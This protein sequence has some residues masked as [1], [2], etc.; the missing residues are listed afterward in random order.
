MIIAILAIAIGI[1]VGLWM[2]HN[3]TPDAVPFLAIAIIAALDSVFGGITAYMQKQFDITVFFT[4]LFT[5][6]LLAVGIL[7]LGDILGINFPMLLATIVIFGTRMFQNF[8]TMRYIF[9]EKYR[10]KG[11]GKYRKT[12]ER[13]VLHKQAMKR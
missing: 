2:P 8:A 7:Y 9:L 5:N 6:A 12:A 13:R 10:R 11:L 3:L 4:G 1:F